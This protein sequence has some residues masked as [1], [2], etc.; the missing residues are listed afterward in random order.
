MQA[1][2]IHSADV[3]T[4]GYLALRLPVQHDVAVEVDLQ[5]TKLAN[6]HLAA[7]SRK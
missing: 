5:T 1:S 4:L 3:S 2:N 7:F 6:R